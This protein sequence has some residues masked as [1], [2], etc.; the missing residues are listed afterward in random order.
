[1]KDQRYANFFFGGSC[2]KEGASAGIFLISP[3]KKS[4]TFSFKLEF[5]TTNNVVSYEPLLIGLK[6]AKDM[7]ILEISIFRKIQCSKRLKLFSPKF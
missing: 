3:F 5:D 7:N 1:M 2:S 4:F 6:R